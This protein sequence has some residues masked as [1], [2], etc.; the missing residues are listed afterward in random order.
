MKYRTTLSICC[1]IIS[2]CA[3]TA[4]TGL[5]D[6]ELYHLRDAL[7]RSSQVHDTSIKVIGLFIAAI[8]LIVAL[9]GFIG[10]VSIHELRKE[11][12]KAMTELKHFRMSK[13]MIIKEISNARKVLHQ[14]QRVVVEQSTHIINASQIDNEIKTKLRR[15][16]MELDY[17]NDFNLDL[18][19]KENLIRIRSSLD[20]L[21][22]LGTDQS[23][24]YIRD[25]DKRLRAL[26]FT[27]SDLADVI[28]E[29]RLH[30]QIEEAILK[31]RIRTKT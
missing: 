6:I 14:L 11:M 18:F 3:L 31:I 25:F 29:M 13:D 23:I 15:V 9:T 26:I 27:N 21:S 10:Y 12:K 4:Q 19:D 2:V 1:V 16:L 22:K 20:Q 30:E 7:S 17:I 8:T 24:D 5:T 28:K